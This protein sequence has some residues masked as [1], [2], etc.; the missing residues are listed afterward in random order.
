[1][2]SSNKSFGIVFGIFFSILLSYSFYKNQSF[3]VYYLT[4][5][6]L[7]FILG[8]L[9]SKILT[10]FNKTWI[11]FG[12]LL[13]IVISPIVMA[14]VYFLTIFPTTILLKLFGKDLLGLKIDKNSNSFWIIRK[15]KFNTMNKQF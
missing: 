4:L 10:P 12:E 14:I 6:L 8:F 15:N 9:N 3:N 7:F 1:M 2:I 5:A 13:G 11:K